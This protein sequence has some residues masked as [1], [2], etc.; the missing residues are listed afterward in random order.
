MLFRQMQYLVALS[1]ESHFGRAAE[2]CRVSQP[3]LSSAIKQLE[4]VLGVPIVMRGR[5]FMGFTPEG[6]RV[7]EWAKR[8]IAQ[9]DAMMVELSQMREN[10]EGRIRVGA[11]PNS[12][13]ILPIF[14]RIL[15]E[16]HPNLDIDIRF[17]GVEETRWGLINF[18]LDVGITY[19]DEESL[20]DLQ[21]MPIYNERLSLLVPAESSYA[22]R[23][24]MTWREAAELPLC[25]LD[26]S[27]HER[28]II[29]DAFAQVGHAPKARV[30]TSDSILNLIFHV[31]FADLVTIVPSHFAKLPGSLPGTKAIELVKPDI[32]RQVGLVWSATEPMMPM[33]RMM[34]SIVEGLQKSGEMNRRLGSGFF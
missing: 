24:Q 11:M 33:A 25:L 3:S 5:R 30:T 9:R 31:M 26:T 2:R 18:A 20:S 10:L 17:L 7:V 21:S 19:I 28:R 1:V 12:S 8:V 13:P 4:L 23:T 15:A 16:H 22:E 14:S 29:D 27:M 32:T 34:V 6:K